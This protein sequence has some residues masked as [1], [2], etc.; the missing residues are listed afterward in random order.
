MIKQENLQ[1]TVSSGK[2][3]LGRGYGSGKGG[4]TSSRGQKG[5]KSRSK[6]GL[7]F[8]G[9]K[10]KKSYVKKLP[11]WRGKG[12]LKPDLLVELDLDWLEKNTK[13]GDVVDRKY[14]LEKGLL[15]KSAKNIKIKVLSRGKITKS[16]KINLPTAVK[17]EKEIKKAGGEVIKD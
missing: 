10:T 8:T 3:R 15:D 17:A 14:L 4:H 6:V 13:N 1:P 9:T 7:L 5:Q 16:L 12:R 11:L 2:K